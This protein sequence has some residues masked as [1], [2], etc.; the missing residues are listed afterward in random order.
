MGGSGE[1]VAP[2]DDA[3]HQNDEKDEG[4]HQRHRAIAPEVADDQGREH[5][6]Q[7]G[8]CARQ[9]SGHTKDVT[10]GRI[11]RHDDQGGRVGRQGRENG[12]AG[13]PTKPPPSFGV[14]F[15]DEIIE[16]FQ[17]PSPRLA[18]PTRAQV[19]LNY[20]TSSLFCR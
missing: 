20:T 5:D 16:L 3:R 18:S 12:D 2:P 14:L 15:I 6:Q 10:Q 4:A 7:C 9:R 13:N 11:E 19:Y 17:E 1:L 8:K